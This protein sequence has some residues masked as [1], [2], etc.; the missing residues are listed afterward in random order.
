MTVAIPPHWEVKVKR[1]SIWGSGLCIPVLELL[2]VVGATLG[3]WL[4]PVPSISQI[5][6][7][8]VPYLVALV[9]LLFA[10]K[11]AIVVLADRVQFSLVRLLV[12]TDMT[13]FT[14]LFAFLFATALSLVNA[15]R[16]PDPKDIPLLG[17]TLLIAIIFVGNFVTRL[18]FTDEECFALTDELRRRGLAQDHRCCSDVL[19]TAEGSEPC[20]DGQPCSQE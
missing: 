13:L 7:M 18:Y 15:P 12:N 16:A 20:A 11:V 9:F 4:V 3:V 2:A 8:W 6:A 5:L 19:P 14:L 17:L 1:R 10:T